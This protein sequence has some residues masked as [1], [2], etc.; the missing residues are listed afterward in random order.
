[1]WS[2]GTSCAVTVASTGS[3]HILIAM[4]GGST[5]SAVSDGVNAWVHAPNCAI[6]NVDCWY[7]LSSKPGA[8]SIKGTVP[9]GGGR[10]VAFYEFSVG[11]GC[12]AVLDSSNSVADSTASLSQPGIPLT[13]KGTNDVIVQQ[14]FSGPSILSINNGYTEAKAPTNLAAASLLNTTSGAAPAWTLQSSASANV[15]AIAISE[16]CSVSGP[17][18]VTVSP[19]PIS[20]IAAQTQQFVA[21]VTGSANTAVNWSVNPLVGSVS[22]SGL[23]TAPASLSSAQNVTLTATSA[24][25]PSQSASA[26]CFTLDSRDSGDVFAQ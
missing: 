6:G 18:S 12:S 2:S 26:R 9:S 10:G 1:M 24:A 25:N 19:T 20:L 14:I 17:V 23:Y 5:P 4:F 22:N 16:S 13:L 8:T 3:G 21:T 7:V 15:S 11:A